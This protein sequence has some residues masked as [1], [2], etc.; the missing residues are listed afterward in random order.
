M[1]FYSHPDKKLV[2]HL[3]EVR[4]W[5]IA[6]CP[7]KYKEIVEV[8]SLSHDF[9][10]FTSYFQE[11]LFLKKKNDQ[12]H[13]HGFI[14]ALFGAFW[15]L[16]KWG[17][18]SF[19]PLVV[20]SAIHHHHG[21]LTS[22]GEILPNTVSDFGE[23][24]KRKLK[25][26]YQQ[27]EDI[28]NHFDDVKQDV[29]EIIP[30]DILDDFVLRFSP[31]N[32]LKSL[33]KI[34]HQFRV[35]NKWKTEESYFLHQFVYS[36]L[37]A[38][39]K[40]SAASIYGIE[41]AFVEYE[42]CLKARAKILPAS[43]ANDISNIRNEIFAKVQQNMEKNWS[44]GKIFTLTSPT[45]SG[46]TLTGF[47]AANM[48]NQF[49]G[50]GRQ[51]IYILPF[52]SI[53]D[54][55]YNVIEKLLHATSRK[56]DISYLLKHHHLSSDEIIGEDEDYSAADWKLIMENWPSGV[57]VTTFVQFFESIISH[58]NRMLKKLHRLKKAI[59]LIDEIQALDFAYYKLV[60]Y[61]LSMLCQYYDARVILMTATRPFLFAGDET[62]PAI[63]LLPEYPDYYRYFNR[64][65]LNIVQDKMPVKQMV[66]KFS[67]L[68]SEDLSC[69]VVLNTINS[70]L[71]AYK[72]I[73]TMLEERNIN[74]PLFYL[75]TNLVPV[76]RRQRIEEIKER[77][78][79]GEKV[80]LVSTQV[81]EAGVDLDFDIV[82]RDFAPLDSIIQCAGRCNRSGMQYM[83]KKG[84][85]Y[86][87]C[88]LV[89]DNGHSYSYRIYGKTNLNLTKEILEGYAKIEE[90]DYLT[91]IEKYY[92]L[93][94]ENKS[95][96][97][98]NDLI[99]NMRDF[100]IKDGIARFSLIKNNPGYI[101]VLF[102]LNEEAENAYQEFFEV[103][104]IKDRGVK[105]EKYLRISSILSR[106]TISMPV[107][108]A[109]YFEK[110]PLGDGFFFSLPPEGCRDYYDENVGFLRDKE[111][112][113]I[114]C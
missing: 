94:K 89:D 6:Y 30:E 2:Q 29:A 25:Q 78:Q 82:I 71:E 85:V 72:E 111:D 93:L 19:F 23:N 53:I 11:Y 31:D 1:E 109:G 46:K 64:T 76:H 16:R 37:I 26:A 105:A 51:I 35:R 63:E 102:R 112:E 47:C 62:L 96:Q 113:A 5:A 81:V 3:C 101:D 20:Y 12:L 43:S 80:I 91:I 45:G 104:K 38:A 21:N 107:K 95:S 36:S 7:E 55:N 40:L 90:R 100:A 13:H 27:I 74:K 60:E 44:K 65:V 68:L 39:D 58:R 56:D 50:G 79:R 41:P 54:Q 4:D 15:A 69:L 84:E 34:N 24:I 9:G 32:Y 77:M 57:V 18:D 66:E 48:L 61:V 10:K 49:L 14:S 103:I 52:T 88:D 67:T 99:Q 73:K 98:S 8:T 28:K 114:F 97:T 75:S 106:Y 86:L 108:Y 17:D 33:L 42:E 59:I 70:S 92:S 87:I 22:Y 83:E 110:K